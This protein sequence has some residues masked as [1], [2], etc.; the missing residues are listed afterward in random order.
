V[1]DLSR[2]NKDEDRPR[3]GHEKKWARKLTWKAYRL[4]CRLKVRLGQD[5]ERFFRTEGWLTY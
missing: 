5:I 4:E 1:N 3:H 2:T